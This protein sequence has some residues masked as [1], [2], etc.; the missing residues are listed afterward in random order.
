VISR[1]TV[2]VLLAWG[3]P[4]AGT[5]GVTVKLQTPTEYQNHPLAL[6]IRLVAI[7][8]QRRDVCR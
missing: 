1:L 4:V 5:R 6:P 7:S 3:G 2:I 8:L